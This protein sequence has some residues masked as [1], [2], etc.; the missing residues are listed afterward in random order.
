MASA[1]PTDTAAYLA[2][3]PDTRQ[4]GAPSSGGVARDVSF[5]T[6]FHTGPR[7]EPVSSAVQ[8]LWV[9]GSSTGATPEVRTPRSFDLF[10]DRTG[11]FSG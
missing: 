6:L 11:V 3:F 10:S 1:A 9:T 4:G 2:G 5:R 7:A 8:R